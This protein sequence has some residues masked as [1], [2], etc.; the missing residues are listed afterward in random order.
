MI[1]VQCHFVGSDFL[2][3]GVIDISLPVM[4]SHDLTDIDSHFTVVYKLAFRQFYHC[5]VIIFAE[6]IAFG[7]PYLEVISL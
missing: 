3:C 1:E 2:H 7:Y 5:L 6:S 4:Q